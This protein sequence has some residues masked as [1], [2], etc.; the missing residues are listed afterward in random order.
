MYTDVRHWVYRCA[1]CNQRTAEAA[2]GRLIA[3][4]PGLKN[5]F[6]TMEEVFGP[7]ASPSTDL[8]VA[9]GSIQGCPNS[10]NQEEIDLK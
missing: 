10:P 4:I 5:T 2:Q 9:P 3:T 6:W 7:I 1:E 8:I